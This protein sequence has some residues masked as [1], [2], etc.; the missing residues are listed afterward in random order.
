[1]Q[2]VEVSFD[3]GDEWEPARVVRSGGLYEWVQWEAEVPP[4]AQQITVRVSTQT[5]QQPAPHDC[6]SNG[7]LFN[8]WETRKI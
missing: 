6:V 1:V 4:D 5:G 8:G 2:S 7:Y 3:N